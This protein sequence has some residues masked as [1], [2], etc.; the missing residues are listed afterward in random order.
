MRELKKALET[1]SSDGARLLPYDLNPVLYEE[2]LDIQPL[3]MML[4]ILTAKTKTHEYRRKTGHPSAWFEGESTTG[5]V[6]NSTNEEKSLKMKI[7]RIWG[8]VSGFQQVMSEEFVDALALEING[9]L[10]GMSNTLEFG[11]MYGCSADKAFSGDAYQ[12]DGLLTQ[13]YLNAAETNVI[14]GGGD[15]ITLADL[16]TTIEAIS[17][18][19]GVAR[20]NKFFLMSTSM[21][22]IID[23][24]QTKVQIPLRSMELFD[25]KL[26]M[27]SYNEIPIVKTSYLKPL[28]TTTS[29]TPVLT[30]STSGGTLSAQAYNYRISSVYLTGEQRGGSA[31]T[32]AA[33]VSTATGS[34]ALAWT[35]DASAKLYMI[36][37]QDGGAGDYALIDI[38]AAKTYDSAGKVSGNVESYTDAGARARIEEVMPLETGE[39]M[40]I[41]V[42]SNPERGAAIMTR[43]DSAGQLQEQM[44]VYE[45]LAKTK[46][47]H[48]YMIKSYLGL[49]VVYPEM[50]AVLRHVK[51]A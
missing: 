49:R 46:D 43:A 6:V 15:K 47:S 40:I 2:L 3:A 23:G 31:A 41:L 45:E 50:C 16:D 29:P 51:L 33:T 7:Q 21:K 39:H 1:T 30:A 26:T 12:Y 36:F 13:I 4:S 27:G 11:V 17:D 25:G 48:D 44:F 22:N 35:A 38:I 42:D 24:L 32:T 18:Y 10:E 28:A 19:R 34:V 37:R 9:S 14:D 5:T 8:S 20:D